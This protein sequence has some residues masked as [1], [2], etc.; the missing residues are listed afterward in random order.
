M[1]IGSDPETFGPDVVAGVAEEVKVGIG[2]VVEEVACAG[3]LNV[4]VFEG[5][6]I[7]EDVAEET[8]EFSDVVSGCAILV[9]GGGVV[10]GGV[11]GG[12]DPPAWQLA[13]LL[14]SRKQVCPVADSIHQ[15]YGKI[16]LG[17]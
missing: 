11:S 10:G 8:E 12:G 6:G 7:T 2:V 13:T 5:G 17:H 4:G 15:R 1:A 3:A 9:V 16:I 14:L